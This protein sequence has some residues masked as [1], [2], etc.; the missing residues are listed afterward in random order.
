M[1]S[2]LSPSGCC[3]GSRSGSARRLGCIKRK[4]AG[5]S[6]QRKQQL[7]FVQCRI[8][9]DFR[10]TVHI[11]AKG[12]VEWDKEIQEL[13][14]S[15]VT[16]RHSLSSFVTSLQHQAC[17]N[18]TFLLPGFQQSQ[19]HEHSSDWADRTRKTSENYVCQSC[20]MLQSAD[21]K[22]H[23]ESWVYRIPS[24]PAYPIQLLH[25]VKTVHEED[26]SQ[27]AVGVD[28]ETHGLH[29]ITWLR[30]FASLNTRSRNG[31]YQSIP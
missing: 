27:A 23:P 10:W 14:V 25:V 15:G 17:C 5:S 18:C 31:H 13:A 11:P 4:S 3:R 26:P 22:D 30:E 29:I 16:P 1:T 9:M 24:V 8:F 6:W 28:R 20:N 7:Q 12:H 21:T 19:L 2:S